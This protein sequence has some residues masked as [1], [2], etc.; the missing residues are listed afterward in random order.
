VGHTDALAAIW[1]YIADSSCRGYS[2]LY[3]HICRT[4]AESD[5]VLDLVTEAPPEGHNPVLLLAAVHHL[6]LGGLE[7]PLAAVYAGES[8]ADPARWCRRC[9]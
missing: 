2:P 7:H 4:V 3:D 6:L 1:I 5:A 9:A 8:D